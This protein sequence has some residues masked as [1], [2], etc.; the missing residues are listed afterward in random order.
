MYLE[1]LSYVLVQNVNDKTFLHR[2]L[3]FAAYLPNI[4]ETVT[5]SEP[6][7]FLKLAL[8]DTECASESLRVSASKAS[9]G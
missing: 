3:S 4:I 5:G 2:A 7:D 6:L 9:H 8:G 1:H